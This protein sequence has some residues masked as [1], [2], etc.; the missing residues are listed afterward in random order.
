MAISYAIAGAAAG[1]VVGLTSTG[2]G[3]LLT[4]ALMFLGV[5]PSI[6]LGA[7]V[8]ASAGMKLVGG[9]IYALRR[10]VRWPTVSRLAI[11]SLP[12]ALLGIT[13]LN[14]FPRPVLDARL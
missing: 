11:G 12:G 1:L 6:C 7:D 4:P 10:A 2:G 3:A 5:A 9:G 14:R 8:V 13:A